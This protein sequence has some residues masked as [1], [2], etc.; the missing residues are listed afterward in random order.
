[1]KP[2]AIDTKLNKLTDSPFIVDTTLRDGEQSPGI[3]FSREEKLK[4]LHMLIDIGVREC[5]IGI[6]VMDERT[7]EDIEV[8]QKA[9]CTR[10]T[11]T[12][13][14]ARCHPKDIEVCRRLGTRAIHLS[15]PVSDLQM[16]IVGLNRT[17]LLDRLNKTLRVARAH[18]SFVSVGAQDATR[19]D[20]DF[21][22][23]YIDTAYHMGVDRI[24][25]ADT[26]GSANPMKTYEHVLNIRNAFKGLQ[27]EF[28]AHNDFGMATANAIAALQAG[29]DGVS[30]TILGIGERAGNASMET[31]VLAAKEIL[32]LDLN[33]DTRLLYPLCQ[34]VAQ[35]SKIDIPPS[36]PVVGDQVLVHESGIHTHGQLHHPKAFQPYLAE[37]VGRSQ[38]TFRFGTHSGRNAVKRLL[39][40]ATHLTPSDALTD[41]ITH[42]IKQIARAE[43][44]SLTEKEVIDIAESI[45]FAAT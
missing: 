7:A 28:H 25:L 45:N 16:K 22:M 24:R 11:R 37:Q 36:H 5:E 19:S 4:L 9:A 33:V 10:G 27:L 42:R 8:L 1:M 21:L 29:A 34:Y 30:T 26:V 6:P 31:V 14:W 38:P 39:E 12:I 15:L 43:K 41:R 17:E 2:P 18:F 20:S 13:C 44:T 23:R 35:I 32:S 3:F 40:A